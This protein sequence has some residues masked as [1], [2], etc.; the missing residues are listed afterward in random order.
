MAFF[1]KRNT[2]PPF[3]GIIPINLSAHFKGRNTRGKHGGSGG[4]RTLN[5]ALKRRLL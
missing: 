3:L 1:C 4:N 2:H 5:L